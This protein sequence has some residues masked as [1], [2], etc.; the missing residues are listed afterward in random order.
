MC[1]DLCAQV[2][3][4]ENP[5][6]HTGGSLQG[7]LHADESAVAE[8]LVAEESQA[9]ARAAAKKA[10]KEQRQKTKRAQAAEEGT[11]VQAPDQAEPQTADQA[12]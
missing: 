10:K 11:A 5:V 1:S 9:A 8:Q 2:G 7:F 12:D 3:F 4:D 6:Q